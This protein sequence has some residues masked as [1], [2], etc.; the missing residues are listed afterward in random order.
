LIENLNNYA[1]SKIWD[2][3]WAAL[4]TL[5][6][7]SSFDLESLESASNSVALQVPTSGHS[8]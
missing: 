8:A 6:E 5:I 4:E 2:S 7:T 3:L 1:H